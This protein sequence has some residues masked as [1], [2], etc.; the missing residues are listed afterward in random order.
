MV[1][2]TSVDTRRDTILP[3]MDD[4]TRVYKSEEARWEEERHIDR[5]LLTG[6]PWNAC[7]LIPAFQMI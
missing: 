5:D 7:C 6:E 2:K 3:V 1:D 4:R